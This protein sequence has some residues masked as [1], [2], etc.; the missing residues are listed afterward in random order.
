MPS[1]TRLGKI[2]LSKIDDAIH[3]RKDERGEL[4]FRILQ[5]NANRGF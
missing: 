3:I 5:W 4:R 2:F 1:R